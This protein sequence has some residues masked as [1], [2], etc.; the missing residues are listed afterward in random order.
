MRACSSRHPWT[1]PSSFAETAEKIVALVQPAIEAISAMLDF[2]V[3]K[4]MPTR[5][6]H[7]RL[8]LIEV[9]L[10]VKSA[11]TFFVEALDQTV[12]FAEVASRIIAII[13]RH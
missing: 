6:Y 2:K 9:V 3:I 12:E 4:D 1:R 7:W 11:A 10:G 5:M 13:Q 8:N